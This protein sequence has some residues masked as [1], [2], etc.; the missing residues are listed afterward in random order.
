MNHTAIDYTARV[1]AA[2][3]ADVAAGVSAARAGRRTTH[4]P[5]PTVTEVPGPRRRGW[6]RWIPAPRPAH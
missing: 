3:R 6:S 5:E 2:H 4:A 1:A